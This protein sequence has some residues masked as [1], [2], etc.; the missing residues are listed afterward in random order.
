M[1]ILYWLHSAQGRPAEGLPYLRLAVDVAEALGSN[2]VMALATLAQA[3][4]SGGEVESGLATLAEARRRMEPDADLQ[5]VV[6]LALAET[7]SDLKLNHL[8]E[9]ATEGLAVW[10]RLQ[11]NGL[12][13][14]YMA[15]GVLCI[16]GEALRG[17]GQI[18]QFRRIVEPLTTDQ[19]V[20][21]ATWLMHVQ[22]CWADL[23]TGRIGA[24]TDRVNQILSRS[25]PLSFEEKSELA[26][27][28]LEVA[29]WGS[30]PRAA[31][32]IAQLAVEGMAGVAPDGWAARLL[33]TAMWASADLVEDA[34]ARRDDTQART[35]QRFAGQLETVRA[36]LHPG[37]VRRASILH[38]RHGRRP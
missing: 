7:D 1:I 5:T 17:R 11:E 32:G 14:T 15:V 16:A 12:A 38:H 31:V 28:R 21:P 30:D 35:G 34:R 13:G 29:L 20:E 2:V 33:T 3:L 27:L 19:A 8:E 9:A 6:R 10:D 23:Y 36:D 25:R 18:A 37:P 26:Q 4:L 22:R 24:A